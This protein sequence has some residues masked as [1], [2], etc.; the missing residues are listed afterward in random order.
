MSEVEPTNP[1]ESPEPQAEQNIAA[2]PR[3]MNIVETGDT[4]FMSPNVYLQMKQMAADFVKAGSLPAS[5]K[6]PEQVLVAFQ[7]G[8][9]MGMKP[10]ESLNSLYPVN[11]SL[12]IWGKAVPRQLKKHGW[13]LSYAE[14]ADECTVTITNDDGEKYSETLKFADAEKSGY[15]K[16]NYGKIKVGWREGV[17]RRLKLRYGAL[18][19]AIKSY[20]PEVLGE[21]TDIAEVAMDYD[22]A[23]DT[24]S[25]QKE[26]MAAAAAERAKMVNGKF[27]PRTHDDEGTDEQVFAKA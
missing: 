1:I 7:M 5:Y 27:A 23:N 2:K 3:S 26:I 24:S 21:A 9:E 17:N 20:V 14:S 15:T 6:T 11:G 18:S 8:R 19:L 13:K 22:V 4:D 10:M 12:N 16:D 25:N